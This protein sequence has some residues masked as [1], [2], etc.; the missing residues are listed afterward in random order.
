ML[1]LL[2]LG[3]IHTP[4]HPPL[5]TPHRVELVRREESLPDGRACLWEAENVAWDGV[6]VWVAE[7]PEGDGWC[8]APREAARMVDVLGQDGP[9]LSVHLRTFECC[10][11]RWDERWLTWDLR[12]GAAATLEAYDERL[13]ARRWERALRQVERDPS[14]RGWVLDRDAFLVGD[15]HVSFVAVHGDQARLVRVK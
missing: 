10:P 12:T 7:P 14:L 15:G 8:E 2:A 13:A 9:F 6:A 3:C 11:E 4:P 5:P 1:L